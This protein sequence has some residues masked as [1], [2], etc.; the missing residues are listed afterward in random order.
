ME[1]L[2]TDKIRRLLG[3]SIFSRNIVFNETLGSTNTA[4][5]DL[6]DM[7]APEGK[8]VLTEE[9]T[10]GRGRMGRRWLSPGYVN[11]LF[12]VLMRPHMKAEDVFGLSMAFAL[13]TSEAVGQVSNLRP[14]IKW[15]NDIYLSGKKLG[16]ML[17]EFSVID[18]YT[19]YAIIGLGLNVNWSPGDEE[20]LLYVSTSLL[21]ESGRHIERE[22]LLAKLL[23]GFEE[24]YRDIL[25]GRLEEIYKAWNK[26]SLLLNRMVDIQTAEGR[27]SGKAIRIDQTGAL[28]IRD[29]GGKEQRILN[30]DVSVSGLSE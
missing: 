13:A 7:G 3:E 15:P 8:I 6:A 24:Y 23:R 25:S 5:K 28:I 14:M 17:T 2:Q 9:Q 12:S 27:K 18:N 29:A 19:E 1:I 10:G 21:A 4:A 20:T 16:G 11:L 22:S 26:R 30:G